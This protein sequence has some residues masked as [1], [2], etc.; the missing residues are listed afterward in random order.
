MRITCNYNCL[1]KL[2]I[3]NILE[4][5]DCWFNTK[6]QR[7]L[8][9]L[10]SSST[11]LTGLI[12]SIE[13]S[14]T[15]W[16]TSKIIEEWSRTWCTISSWKT[17]SFTHRITSFTYNICVIKICAIRTWWKTIQFIFI[18]MCWV[19]MIITLF[20]NIWKSCICYTC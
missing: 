7:L 4:I 12:C 6:L 1:V 16:N 2:N 17:T 20:S 11:R 14:R 13:I 3:D 8:T 19:T 18:L 5:L 15:F 10:Y 9:C